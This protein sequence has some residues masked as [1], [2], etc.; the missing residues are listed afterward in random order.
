MR[1]SRLKA[2]SILPKDTCLTYSYINIQIKHVWFP[3]DTETYDL[4]LLDLVVIGFCFV[5]AALENVH[6][7]ISYSKFYYFLS[8]LR[9]VTI[10]KLILFT[11]CYMHIPLE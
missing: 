3:K 9:F 8:L 5:L 6:E 4:V 10:H 2:L 7:K 11:I 1:E